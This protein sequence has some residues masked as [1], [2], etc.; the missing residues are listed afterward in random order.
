MTVKLPFTTCEPGIEEIT[1]TDLA[2]VRYQA[3]FSLNSRAPQPYNIYEIDQSAIRPRSGKTSHWSVA[4]SDLMMTMFILFLS[5]FVY[6]AAH[7]DFLISDK[8]EIIGGETVAAMEVAKKKEATLPFPVIKP[9]S[10]FITAGKIPQVESIPIKNIDLESTFTKADAQKAMDE[11]AAN[12][13]TNSLEEENPV[14][15]EEQLGETLNGLAEISDEPE[16]EIFPGTD[17]AIETLYDQSEKTIGMNNLDRFAEINLI[18]NKAM[19]IVLTGD[20]L[21]QTGHATLSNEAKASLRKIA[22]NISTTRHQIHVEGHTDD[23]PVLAGRFNN[24]WELSTA[25]ANAVAAF[26]IQEIGMNPRKFIISG[27]ASYNPVV[28]NSNEENRAK[29]RRVEIVVTHSPKQQALSSISPPNFRETRY[30]S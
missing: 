9:P 10:P 1:S 30:D 26:L 8:K 21:F 6:Q 23:V 5:L 14:A 15:E 24:N 12:L 28:P 20:L 17:P 4:W 29:N 7:K 27:Y 25:R 22:E 11:V 18:P 2:A 13:S 3:E 16:E 19:R